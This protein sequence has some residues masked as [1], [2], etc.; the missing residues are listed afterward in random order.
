MIFYPPDVRS[1]VQ[2]DRAFE[3]H[4]RLSFLVKDSY[5]GR[6]P[7]TVNDA[8]DSDTI[9]DPELADLFFLYGRSQAEL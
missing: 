9:A 5:L 1:C 8:S 4:R 6:I 2:A 7:D 3:L